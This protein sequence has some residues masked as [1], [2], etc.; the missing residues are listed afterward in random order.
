MGIVVNLLKNEPNSKNTN[1]NDA[2]LDENKLKFESVS[3]EPSILK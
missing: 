1:G 2:I 3:V